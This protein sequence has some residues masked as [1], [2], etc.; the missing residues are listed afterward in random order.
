MNFFLINDILN[1]FRND[2]TKIIEIESNSEK[3]I[4]DLTFTNF[5]TTRNDVIEKTFEKMLN[6]IEHD[7]LLSF[8][9]FSS[10]DENTSNNFDIVSKTSTSTSLS[11]TFE[12]VTRVFASS[13]NKTKKSKHWKKATTINENN[14][15]L[16][17]IFRS[18]KSNSF[19]NFNHYVVLKN[20]FVE[21]VRSFY[22][23]FCKGIALLGPGPW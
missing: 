5:I 2:F 14:I 13:S 23:T 12:K 21:K 8:V 17:K 3:K 16:E 22:E 4:W 19:R 18:R 7:Y 20:V 6:E 9:S 11:S 15:L 10:K 1:I